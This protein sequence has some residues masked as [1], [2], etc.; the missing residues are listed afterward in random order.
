VKIEFLTVA[1]IELQEAIDYYN[2]Q[3]EGLGDEFEEEVKRTLERI[4]QFPKAWSPLSK[5]AR[6]CILKRFPYGVIYQ[7]RP[8]SILITAVMHLHRDP[9]SWRSRI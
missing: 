1:E 5:R 3:R 9:K 2:H 7:I 8:D 6:R 4:V